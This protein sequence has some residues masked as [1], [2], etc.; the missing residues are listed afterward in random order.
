MFIMLLTPAVTLQARENPGIYM[1]P[2]AYVHSNPLGEFSHKNK[3]RFAPGRALNG[4]SGVEG[5]FAIKTRGEWIIGVGYQIIQY[6]RDMLVMENWM[7]EQY[8]LDGYYTDGN[9]PN[10]TISTSSFSIILSREF[11]V[12]YFSIAPFVNISL[13]KYGGFSNTRLHQKK[14]NDNYWQDISLFGE[15]TSGEG[16]HFF[17]PKIGLTLSRKIFRSIY[18]TANGYYGAGNLK[19]KTSE[20]R[21]DFYGVFEK[22]DI[23]YKQRISAV[24]AS[25]GIEIRFKKKLSA[26]EKAK[27]NIK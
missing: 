11:D 7:L 23:V 6:R 8:N 9:Y 19:Y 18:L 15:Q 17:Y 10:E 16:P 2:V 4:G 14:M 25:I 27:Y 22:R 21:N 12:K 26:E 3:G 20:V 24:S 5:S 1:K 13:G